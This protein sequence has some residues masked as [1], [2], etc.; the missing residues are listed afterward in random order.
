MRKAMILI[1]AL[2]VFVVIIALSMRQ[3]QTSSS[4]VLSVSIGVVGP[5][6]GP[7]AIWGQWLKQG[8]D[9]AFADYGPALSNAH[10]QVKFVYEDSE[11]MPAKA[12]NAV[13][14][15]IALN[16]VSVV[17]GPLSTAEV[18]AIAP[19]AERNKVVLLT[20]SAS[21]KEI[22]NAGDYIF[23]TYPKDEDQSVALAR[24]TVNVMKVHRVAVLYR[25]DDFGVGVEQAYSDELGRL[26]GEKITAEGFDPKTEDFRSLI[27][28]VKAQEP[29]VTLIVG[30]PKDL[31]Q[32]LRQAVE[33]GFQTRFLSTANI[34]N[35][36][37]I[38]IAGIGAEGVLYGS[39]MFDAD[40]T[41]AVVQDFQRR[42]RANFQKTDSAG[43]GVAL[44]YDGMRV[45]LD[46]ICKTP[47]ATA[48]EIKQRL[49]ST[50]AFP[51]V[52]GDITFD[53]NGDV[54]KPFA[55]KAINDGK[56]VVV[57]DRLD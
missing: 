38:K 57:K 27:T 49:Y 35:P 41:N 17:Y 40:S 20:P 29:E 37:V 34:E 1:G 47:G 19:L 25:T 21:G 12:V 5:L 13:Q 31:G 15:L 33:L 48:D 45:L 55:L 50:K 23:R 9:L 2:V 4:E 14:K 43:L 6:S 52:T 8:V 11:G 18:L 22:S 32:I 24:Y 3:K 36:E 28:K 7:G 42:Y 44:A 56:F 30:M 53:S 26:G 54:Q 51:A 16:K 10:R 46:A 39:I